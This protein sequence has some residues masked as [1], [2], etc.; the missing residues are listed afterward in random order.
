MKFKSSILIAAL[1]IAMFLIS[2]CEIYSVYFSLQSTI[3]R[4]MEQD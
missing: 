2:S 3:I 4:G 1:I